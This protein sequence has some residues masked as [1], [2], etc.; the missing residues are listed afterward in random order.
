MNVELMT[1]EPEAARRKLEAYRSRR[2]ADANEEYRRCEEA[3]AAMAAGT[4]LIDLQQVFATCPTDGKGRPKLA[5]A[6]ADRKQV[7]FRSDSRG[8]AFDSR[9]RASWSSSN[10]NNTELRIWFSG[11][12]FVWAPDGYSTIPMV[13]A[14]VRPKHGQLKDWFILW[15]VE[16]WSDRPIIDPPY[17]PY[18][19]KHIGG[20][21]YAVLAEWDL[22]EIERAVMRE[23]LQ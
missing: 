22:T 1:M 23:I 20:T 11:D 14:D 7:F 15:E 2:H 12:R 21:L 16:Q 8:F 6:R 13:P 18:L 10:W 4:P 19:L 5:V 17:D 3:Y 9:A